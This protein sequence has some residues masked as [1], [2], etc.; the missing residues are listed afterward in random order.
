MGSLLLGRGLALPRGPHH[1]CMSAPAAVSEIHSHY[2][3][4][5]ARVAITNSFLVTRDG[6]TEASGILSLSI[7]L[8]RPH[9]AVWF[10]LG[11]AAPAP[12]APPPWWSL[13]SRA[14]ALL[15]E[16]WAGPD[17]EPWLAFPRAIPIVVSF[18]LKPGFTGSLGG[19]SPER[20]A[21]LAHLHGA[22]AVG[23]N[24][25]WNGQG[26]EFPRA[27]EALRKVSV[28]PIVARP[29]SCGLG[30]GA[31]ASMA[32]DC[33]QAGATHI[34]GCCGTTPDHIRALAEVLGALPHS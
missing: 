25:G 12:N 6:E 18:C 34:G 23:F 28:L 8:A 31:W 29:A 7:A 32:R 10:S 26:D 14:D 30:P 27:V 33:V 3:K 9:G 17:L 19:W 20:L 16:T 21:D 15:F 4:A 5:G 24:C 1:A 2:A 22:A 13:V 11:P